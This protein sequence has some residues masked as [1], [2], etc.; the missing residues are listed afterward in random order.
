MSLSPPLSYLPLVLLHR[1]LEFFKSGQ[2]HF[3]YLYNTVKLISIPWHYNYE[4]ETMVKIIGNLCLTPCCYSWCW[5]SILAPKVPPIFI[6]FLSQLI[7]LLFQVDGLFFHFHAELHVSI[8]FKHLPLPA[9][10]RDSGNLSCI[11]TGR[12]LPSAC[13]V[14]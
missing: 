10:V 14:Q 11:C 12:V 8:S 4:N 7:V 13:L 2:K 5:W 9:T 3:Q 6:C 1:L